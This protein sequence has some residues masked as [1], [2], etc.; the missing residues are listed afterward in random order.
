MVEKSRLQKANSTRL[1]CRVLTV[2]LA[3]VLLVMVP[4]ASAQ[5]FLDTSLFSAGPA[6]ATVA[7]WL[8]SR[9]SS[10]ASAQ[11]GRYRD[12]NRQNPGRELCS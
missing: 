1:P 11:K 6:G 8:A 4:S 3:L 5:V 7:A 10:R 9:I 12:L 2:V